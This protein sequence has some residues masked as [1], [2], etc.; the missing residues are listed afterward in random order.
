[1][2]AS[3]GASGGRALFCWANRSLRAL[4]GFRRGMIPE[5]T[6]LPAIVSSIP[7][8][9]PSVLPGGGSCFGRSRFDRVRHRSRHPP[10]SSCS[11]LPA[12]TVVDRVRW[13]SAGSGRRASTVL[14][15]PHPAQLCPSGSNPGSHV[16]GSAA[17]GSGPAA[18]H[19]D[20]GARELSSRSP[21]PRSS[22]ATARHRPGTS[23]RGSR[24]PAATNR[25]S[26]A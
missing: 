14:P 17:V 18:P 25:P 13:I 19:R 15:A 3:A 4:P 12:R 1:M 9:S 10:V 24:R 20:R 11:F 7:R 16:S 5:P 6:G 23:T 8:L 22:P 21:D 2:A 26:P